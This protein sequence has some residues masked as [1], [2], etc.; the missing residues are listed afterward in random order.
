MKTA[1]AWQSFSLLWCSLSFK[2]Q[3][4][5]NRAK[6]P[7][8]LGG[9]GK[10]VYFGVRES[11]GLNQEGVFYFLGR[12][13]YFWGGHLWGTTHPKTPLSETP[14]RQKRV[15]FCSLLNSASI[16]ILIKTCNYNAAELWGKNWDTDAHAHMT[17]Q[18]PIAGLH[19]S[20][21]LPFFRIPL[22]ILC[23]NNPGIMEWIAAPLVWLTPRPAPE[24]LCLWLLEMYTDPPFTQ[25]AQK[26][27]QSTG[28]ELRIPM[29]CLKFR[30]SGPEVS[31]RA[32]FTIFTIKL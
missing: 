32:K 26:G 4:A 15:P 31:P 1:C 23:W 20:T 16:C 2:A 17:H 8:G 29:V 6:S 30:G 11:V 28:L 25:F 19:N 27:S 5:L 24:C 9:M 22:T 7:A 12:L 18:A 10:N 21:L 3:L 13:L 14:I